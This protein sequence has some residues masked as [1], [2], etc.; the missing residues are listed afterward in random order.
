MTTA[1]RLAAPLRLVV[2]VVAGTLVAL[3]F[4]L[5]LG[6]IAYDVLYFQPHRSQIAQMVASATEEERNPPE[7]IVHLMRVAIGRGF[8]QETAFVLQQL[9]DERTRR[10]NWHF[11]VAL[12]WAC[13]A[14]HLSERE[15]IAIIASQRG[16]RGFSAASQK[17][18]QRPLASLSLSQAATILAIYPAP[19]YYLAKHEALAVR[20]DRL[21]SRLESG[22]P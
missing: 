11:R 5:L 21:L 20:R 2:K 19:N 8:A 10:S 18:F 22:H 7:T 12:W 3:I 9:I 14:V 15:Q 1:L 17:L 13:V 4:S 16:L 6:F